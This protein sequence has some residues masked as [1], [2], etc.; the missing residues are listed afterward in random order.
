MQ[1]VGWATH[2]MV[3]TEPS[4]HRKCIGFADLH[5]DF[6]LQNLHNVARKHSSIMK[7]QT[8]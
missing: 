8:Y 1:R 3:I 2:I 5:V 4:T 6:M 7:F